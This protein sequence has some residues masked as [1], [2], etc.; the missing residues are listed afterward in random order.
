[1]SKEEYNQKIQ[2][3]IEKTSLTL[4]QKFFSLF[5][6]KGYD[7]N[8]LISDLRKLVVDIDFNIFEFTLFFQE[9]ER[10]ILSKVNKLDYMKYKILSKKRRKR[11]NKFE[12]T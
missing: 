7:K 10:K 11:C 1:M 12:S 2:K 4:N 9:I 3:L 5:N 6:D 8:Q